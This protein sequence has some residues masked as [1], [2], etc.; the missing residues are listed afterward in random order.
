MDERHLGSGL[1]C[2][3]EVAA[4]PGEEQAT[5]TSGELLRAAGQP[6]SPGDPRRHLVG[7]DAQGVPEGLLGA[8]I[9]SEGEQ[10]LG[11]GG[12]RLGEVGV[13]G[14]GGVELD[15][16]QI[17]TPRDPEREAEPG[18]RL[19]EVGRDLER[20]LEGHLGTF[21]VAVRE[22][23]VAAPDLLDRACVGR[24]GG[25]PGE[26]QEER[27]DA[28]TG[29]GGRAAF[30]EHALRRCGARAGGLAR[31]EEGGSGPEFR[32]SSSRSAERSKLTLHAWSHRFAG[33]MARKKISTTVYIT[34]EQDERLKL[35]NDRTKVP[36]AEYIRQGIDLVLE[37]YRATLPGQLT[38]DDME[39]KR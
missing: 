15:E 13:G 30:V 34:P 20:V 11:P 14:D 38:L 32:R 19:P 24:G 9:L 26:G 27:E 5:L 16:R 29:V 35:L 10:R 2:V 7:V 25:A 12:V 18:A 36:V 1:G 33:T 22:P 17:G 23:L 37:K 21:A 3:E 6:A 28:R 39:R 31:G 8:P 4:G